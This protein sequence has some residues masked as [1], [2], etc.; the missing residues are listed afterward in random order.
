L[1]SWRLWSMA[2]VAFLAF[3]PVAFAQAGPS[4]DELTGAASNA[5]WLHPNHDYEGWRYVEAKQIT[6]A[7]VSTLR[8]VCMYQSKEHV[9]AQPT[10]RVYEGVL[11]FTTT[12]YTIA[13]NATD[14][15]LLWEH[16]WE[17]HAREVFPPNRGGAIKDGKLL[18]GTADGYLF[19]LNAE[20]G[21]L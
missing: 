7:N 6:R 12:H 15:R 4:Q 8:P 18:R 9:P 1:S 5:N 19:A 3:V 11:Y 16:K 20:T 13:I 2:G 10:P 21:A 17:P 14:C